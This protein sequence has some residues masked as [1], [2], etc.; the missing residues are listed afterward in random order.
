MGWVALTAV[1]GF[2]TSGRLTGVALCSGERLLGECAVDLAAGREELLLALAQELLRRHG[3]SIREVGRLGVSLGPG[4]FTGIRVGVA[5]AQA[6]AFAAG[7]PLVGVPSHQA[8][9]FPFA[10]LDVTLVLLT[11]LRKGLVFTE[12]GRWEGRVWRPAYPGQSVPVEALVRELDAV[13]RAPGGGRF[14]FLGE[15]V[16]SVRERVPE[17]FAQGDRL[18]SGLAV[19]RRPGPVALLAAAPESVAV[20]PSELD[21]LQPLYLRAADARK[22]G[23]N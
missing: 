19:M 22:P 15:A 1:L 17:L 8:M 3:L 23:T 10:G 21:G 4:S 20:Q 7:I 18:G 6:L 16:E 14:L 13:L 5:A 9:A 2:E 12:V 11:G